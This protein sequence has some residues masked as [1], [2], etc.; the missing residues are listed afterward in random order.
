MH[1]AHVICLLGGLMLPYTALGSGCASLKA[2]IRADTNRDGLVDIEG[3]SD[4]QGKATWTEERG[5]IF[6]PNIGDTDRRCS[7]LAL[8]GPALTNEQLGNCNDASDNIQR[9]PELLASLRTVPI[10]GLAT[11]AIGTVF[12]SDAVARNNTRIFRRDGDEWVFTDQSYEFSAEEL[13]SGLELG[14]DARDIRRP[15]GWDGRVSVRFNVEDRNSTASDEVA[16]RVA[17]V[18]THHH[19]QNVHQVL[20]VEGNTTDTPFLLKFTKDLMAVVSDAGISD[21]YKFNASDDIWAQDFVE[22]AYASMPG[23]KGSVSIRIMIRCPQDERVAGRQL[24]E[25]YRQSG[26]G[27]VQHLGGARDEINS[28]GNIEA[29]PPYRFN[30]T[31]WPAGRVILG[32]HGKQRH[33]ITP[34]LEA[35]ETQFPIHVDTAWLGIGHVDEFLQF[36][37]ADNKR[38]WVAMIDDP[39]AGIQLLK[40]LKAAGHGSLPAISRKNDTREPG[41]DENCNGFMCNG[42]IP[43]TAPTIAEALA[44]EDLMSVNRRCAQRIEANIQILREQVGLTADDIIRLPSLF[45]QS[46]FA[47][48]GS[49]ILSVGAFFPGVINNLVLTGTGTCIAPNPWGPSVDGVDMMASAINAR[50]AKIGLEVQYIDDWNTHHNF[51]GEVHCGTNSVRDP[52]AAWW[53]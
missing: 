15:G 34:L 44:N 52:S 9:A 39:L 21:F 10:V 2:D 18:L 36:L 32:N 45:Q 25:Y 11:T 51:G 33:H 43:V 30:G 46:A 24:F 7:K 40:D 6:L 28:G 27:A 8:S 4:T 12:V 35:Q 1:S 29:I 31:S 19:L 20:A 47:G 50:Y 48:E 17:P 14:I 49:E 26:V 38:G 16:L 13:E 37:P 22:P 3:N 42:P 41:Q 53:L 5:A 23:P